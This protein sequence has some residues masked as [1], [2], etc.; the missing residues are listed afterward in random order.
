MTKVKYPKNFH[1]GKFAEKYG[2]TND[3]FMIRG[4]FLVVKGMDELTEDDLLDCAADPP[5]KGKK[6]VTFEDFLDALTRQE[7]NGEKDAVRDFLLNWKEG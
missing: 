4:E 2:L 5:Q 6:A 7:L 3:D 1:G